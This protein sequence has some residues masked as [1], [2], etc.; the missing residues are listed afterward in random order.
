MFIERIAYVDYD[1]NKRE[2]D[3]RFNLTQ[4]ELMEME[5]DTVG[6]LEESIK[7][8]IDGLDSKAIGKLFKTIIMKSYGEKSADGKRFMKS[9][10]ISKAFSE[11]EAYNVLYMRLLTDEA[12]A[13][14]FISNLVPKVDGAGAKVS[15]PAVVK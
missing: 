7:R 11:T 1:G 2:E 4:A 9:E 3:F 10:E 15:A 6:G 13:N 5:F 8:M 12:F 14:K